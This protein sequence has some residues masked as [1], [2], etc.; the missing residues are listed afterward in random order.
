M[1]NIALSKSTMH[2]QRRKTKTE[3]A[4]KLVQ[5]FVNCDTDKSNLVIHWDS[6]KVKLEDG[7][8]EERLAILLQAVK[9]ERDP[10]FIGAPRTPD[11][12]GASMRDAM[13]QLLR[14]I[15][16]ENTRLMGM[17]CD[18]TASNTGA[19]NGAAS[20]L[21]LVLDTA[22]LWL[23]CRHHIAELPITWA[24]HAMRNPV[25]PGGIDPMLTRFPTYFPMLRH[26]DF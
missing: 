7:T 18:S 8:I 9:T 25:A 24:D 23:M 6:K 20:L 13:V 3:L 16:V 5:N 2:R 10:Q 19:Q 1:K 17:C 14:D 15:G 4:E 26:N 22:L 11:G 12:T 21:E